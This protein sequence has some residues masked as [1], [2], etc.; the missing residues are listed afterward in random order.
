MK[1]GS[2]YKTIIIKTANVTK[3]Q[4][5]KTVKSQNGDYYKTTTYTKRR[6]LQILKYFNIFNKNNSFFLQNRKGRFL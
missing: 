4:N 3:P 5:H 6:L 1:K 2:G